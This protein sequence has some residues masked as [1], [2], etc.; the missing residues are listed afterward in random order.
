MINFSIIIPTLGRTVE[1]H[2][3]LTSILKYKTDQVLELIII[4]QNEDDRLYLIIQE[5]KNKLPIMHCHVTFKGASKARNYGSTLAKGSYLAFPDD[6]C[7]ILEHTFENAF[8]AISKTNGDIVYGKCVDHDGSDSVT[9]F[10]KYPFWLSSNNM[11]GG[12]V[13]ATTFCSRKV[14]D[15]YQF[16][17]NMGVGT[18]FGAE[19]AYDWLYRILKDQNFKAYYDPEIVFYHPKAINVK[20]DANSLRRV[21]TYSCGKAYLY[22]KHK[23][24]YKYFKEIIK[25]I[26]GIILYLLIKP[27]YSKFYRVQLYALLVGFEVGQ[28]TSEIK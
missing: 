7:M 10:R 20:G 8:N 9:V 12:F 5:F 4:D 26:I 6:D 22:K 13:E 15:S 19:E 3:L 17:E 25:S 23:F 11:D 16:D 24:Y 27:M 14:F 2:H 1:L 28:T 21:F 18:F